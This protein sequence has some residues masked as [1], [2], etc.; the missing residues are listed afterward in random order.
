MTTAT[1]NLIRVGSV[2]EV[3]QRGCMVVTGGGH[4]IAV[5]R[6]DDEFAAVDNRCPHMGFPLDRGTVKNGILT[7]HWHHARFDLLSGGTF[8]PFADDVRSFPVSVEDDTV[9]VDPSPPE[10]DPIERW[11]HRM[12][13]GLEHNIRLVIAKS[14]L[15]LNSADADYRVPLTIGA[16]F[17]TTYSAKGWGQAMTM[18]TCAANFQKHLNDED[19]TRA[20]YQ[21]LRQ[22]AS[23][24]AGR[25]PRFLVDPLPTGET[26]PKVFKDWFRSFIEVRDDEGAER[27]LRT[28][29]DLGISQREIE[30]MVFAA[31]TDRIYLDAG[32]VLDF[33]NKAFEILDHIGWEHAG[34]VLTSLVHGMASARRSE[35]LNSWRNPIDL[36]SLVWE[37]REALPGLWEGGAKSRGEWDEEDALV[38][39]ILEDDP[40]ATIKALKDAV[41][42][43]ATA[44]QLGGAVAYAAFLRMARFHTSNE[45]GDWDTVHN[46]LTAANALHQALK[47]APS[48]ELTRAVFDVAMSIYLDRFLNMP[49]QRLPEPNGA[50]PNEDLGESILKAMDSQQQVE[51]SAGLVSDYVS[52]SPD[53]DGVLPVLAHAMLREDSTFH[54]F[55]IVEA[56]LKQYEDRRGTDSARHALVAL[57]RFL[58]AHYPTP[59]AVNQ[60]YGIAVR[61]QRGDEIF[62]EE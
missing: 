19:K 8:D 46:T 27:S 56:A 5:F 61:L 20:L 6:R 45:F 55:Q 60:T 21:G 48:I 2:E 58:A 13:D 10:P 16:Q 23:E 57:A 54:H 1:K 30:D 9:W 24:C 14:V 36:S 41:R 42:E 32:H 52:S 38:G 25:P 15:G 3:K 44:E 39:V 4:T 49:A 17:G 22:V 29:I 51:Q 62:R 18:L 43:G 31:A 53:P 34:Q 12:E 26:R 28:A 59:R 37:A 11:S 33:C 35:E 47:R 40:V 50:R 7:C